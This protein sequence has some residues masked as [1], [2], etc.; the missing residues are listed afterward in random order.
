MALPSE[1]WADYTVTTYY[2]PAS[3]AKRVAIAVQQPPQASNSEE[4]AVV[5]LKKEEGGRL[6]CH[7]IYSTNEQGKESGIG[8]TTAAQSSSIGEEV[9]MPPLSKGVADTGTIY[10]APAC[11]EK[12]VTSEAPQL[13]RA[14]Y[15]EEHAMALSSQG[16]ADYT[17][18]TTYGIPARK[19]KRVASEG[20][21][22][23]RAHISE[24][25]AIALP[26]NLLSL[27]LL[28]QQARLRE[29]Y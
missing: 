11:K 12:R 5:L 26:S 22:A 1:G 3:K 27:H 13:P 6:Y 25:V 17:V 7:Y 16:G 18:S 21:W 23:H 15:C 10:H 8:G 19:A 9:A 14:H 29:W 28:Y 24:E 2:V 4:V 20:L